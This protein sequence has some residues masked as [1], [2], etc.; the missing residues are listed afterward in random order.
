MC[1]DDQACL[2]RI[3]G[4][5][6]DV[7]VTRIQNVMQRI[8][9]A[10]VNIP[11]TH[12]HYVANALLNMAVSKMMAQDGSAETSAILMRLGDYVSSGRSPPSPEHAMDL[13]A[14]HS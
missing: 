12:R 1:S 3:V 2:T 11:P 13:S 5:E 6:C 4:D 7:Q 14:V 8:E 9:H 10:L